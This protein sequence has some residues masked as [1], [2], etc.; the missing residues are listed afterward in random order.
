MVGEYVLVSVSGEPL[1]FRIYESDDTH[2]DVVGGTLSLTDAGAA[3][4]VTESQTGMF[5]M[6]EP[7]VDSVAGVYSVVDGAIRVDLPNSPTMTLERVGD[8]LAHKLLNKYV[9]VWRRKRS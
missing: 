5:G 7:Q 2:Q 1:P 4:F 8:E 9:F 6:I 3:E